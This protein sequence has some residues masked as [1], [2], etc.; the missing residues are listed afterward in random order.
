[1]A[2]HSWAHSSWWSYRWKGRVPR[3]VVRQWKRESARVTSRQRTAADVVRAMSYWRDGRRWGAV[4]AFLLAV[5]QV[6]LAFAVAATVGLV[7][8]SI[9]V[10]RAALGNAWRMW[11]WEGERLLHLRRSEQDWSERET[12]NAKPKPKPRPRPW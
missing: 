2:N 11:L 6:R 3:A 1:M 12:L 10:V 8:L 7:R 4:K 5:T 9:A